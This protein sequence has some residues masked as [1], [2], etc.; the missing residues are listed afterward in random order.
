[1]GSLGSLGFSCGRSTTSFNKEVFSAMANS[2]G[3]K[4][5]RFW[6]WIKT[7]KAER[8]R[9][10]ESARREGL[11][12]TTKNICKRYGLR[13]ALGFQDGRDYILLQKIYVRDMDCAPLSKS[14]VSFEPFSRVSCFLDGINGRLANLESF[15][16]PSMGH[17]IL[18]LD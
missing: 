2:L 8:E 6:R 14:K 5:W 7:G 4:D 1:M 9:E 18:A 12:F 16:V 11:H 10:T 15:G 3:A 17:Q 13:R